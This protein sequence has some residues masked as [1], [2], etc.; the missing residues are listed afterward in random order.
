MARLV[1]PRTG[2]Y[3]KRE[4]HAGPAERARAGDPDAFDW[5]LGLY[6]PT[7]V[8]G[9]VRA[10]ARFGCRRR[11][12]D[13]EFR[14]HAREALWRAVLGYDPS[15]R[16]FTTYLGW[17]CLGVTS[18]ECKLLLR[19]SSRPPA[20]DFPDGAD[21]PAPPDPP[22][23][24]DGSEETA[25]LLRMGLSPRAAGAVLA[26]LGLP[27][28]ERPHTLREVAGLFGLGDEA[29]AASFVAVAKAKAARAVVRE[30]KRKTNAVS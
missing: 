3:P 9:C 27:P 10:S 13:E 12:T 6:L 4:E 26:R 23:P 2:K 29:A 24:S 11:F 7:A 30:R 18:R 16:E 14:S 22:P 17:H 28:Y 5:F 1:V 25:A 8:G 19:Q 20:S 21:P 15:R